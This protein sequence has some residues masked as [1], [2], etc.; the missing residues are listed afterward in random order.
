[1]KPRPHSSD[2]SR[3]NKKSGVAAPRPQWNDSIFHR[4]ESLNASRLHSTTMKK[5]KSSDSTGAKAKV[6]QVDRGNKS[7][8]SSTTSS[9]IHSSALS[10]PI[11]SS[12]SSSP[13][14]P[15]YFAK[16]ITEEEQDSYYVKF[17]LLTVEEVS[18]KDFVK[19]S[20]SLA[21]EMGKISEEIIN[22]NAGR[23]MS[24]SHA[25]IHLLM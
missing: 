10:S 1:M 22:P 21:A 12:S 16:R 23:Y 15:P 6:G 25:I 2:S 5:T 19:S 8:D 17:H 20:R 9:P 18:T 3:S 7:A 11:Y 24:L 4:P 13:I 14:S